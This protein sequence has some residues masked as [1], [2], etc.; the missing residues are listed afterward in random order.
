[1]GLPVLDRWKIFQGQDPL[2]TQYKLLFLSGPI[3]CSQQAPSGWMCSI[4]DLKLRN[5][6][7][8]FFLELS[9][10]LVLTTYR[11]E[12]RYL[13]FWLWFDTLF[14]QHSQCIALTLC[15]SSG[16]I[17]MCIATYWLRRSHNVHPLFQYLRCR[18]QKPCIEL[19]VLTAT[20]YMQIKS[21]HL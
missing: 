6:L 16:Y 5:K 21:R 3:Y 10:D 11:H 15:H 19:Q 9:C 7:L 1:M 2:D 20:K 13:R 14:C 18:E 12:S 8:Y 17:S 4:C